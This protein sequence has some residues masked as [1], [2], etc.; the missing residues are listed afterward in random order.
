MKR[1]VRAL[2][3]GLVAAFALAAA[4]ASAAGDKHD[5]PYLA[6]GDSYAFAY[7]PLVVA[8]GGASNPANFQGYTDIVAAARD[9]HL[10]N[11]ACPG[12][13]SDSMISGTRPDNGCQ[14]FRAQFP[15]HTRYSGS[16]LD[17][18]VKYLQTHRHTDLVTL[19]IG[20]NDV[21]VLANGCNGDPSCVLGRLEPVLARMQANLDRIYS[22]LRER[23][24]YN[25]TIVAV[26]YFAFDY[27]DGSA[28][29]AVVS[30]LDA[31]EQAVAVRHGALVADVFGAFKTA[32]AGSI[33]VPGI[34]CFAGL[35]IVTNPGPPVPQCDIH[36][37]P[38]GHALIAQT[39]FAVA[40]Q[41]N[42]KHN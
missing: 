7:N 9:L 3:L 25:G 16:Q 4:P 1:G 21:I 31:A 20:G 26:P 10:V 17:F 27:R 19:Q 38:A 28:S 8:G 23:G 24:H 36:P 5:E 42:D 22:E 18:A 29:K 39:I 35:Q 2:V 33:P 30:A 14:D 41:D 15:L 12:E 37:S 34:P 6:L 32:S 13:T 40:P 11:A